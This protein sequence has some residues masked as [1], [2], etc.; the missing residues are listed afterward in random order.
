MRKYTRR[1]GARLSPCLSCC[2]VAP[3]KCVIDVA[4]SH[5]QQQQQCSTQCCTCYT[6]IRN[7]TICVSLQVFLYQWLHS[8]HS[9]LDSSQ[10]VVLSSTKMSQ[11]EPNPM[12]DN[13][14]C[15]LYIFPSDFSY[16]D[17]LFGREDSIWSAKTTCHTCV[18]RH[19]RCCAHNNECM[20]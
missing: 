11:L 20:T 18:L 9:V 1:V 5:N 17:F 12:E 6:L 15:C 19:A 13:D 10:P 3:K 7:V 2:T 16:Q 4:H 8:N 14:V